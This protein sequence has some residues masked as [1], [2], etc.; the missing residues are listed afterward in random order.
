MGNRLQS[1]S[2][3][4][5]ATTFVGVVWYLAQLSAQRSPPQPE[6]KKAKRVKRQ[7]L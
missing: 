6:N 4:G 3:Y 5:E 2:T 1:G 7:I